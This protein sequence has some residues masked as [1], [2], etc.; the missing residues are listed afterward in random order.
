VLLPERTVREILAMEG[1]ISVSAVRNASP[2][3]LR[4]GPKT[5]IRD[6]VYTIR[7]QDSAGKEPGRS[8]FVMIDSIIFIHPLCVEKSALFIGRQLLIN[9]LCSSVASNGYAQ[10]AATEVAGVEL[11][12]EIGDSHADFT[13]YC[14]AGSGRKAISELP[15][16]L[17]PRAQ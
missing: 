11:S 15:S 8:E 2:P 14:I 3:W 17:F 16:A 12:I 4:L 7:V 13:V 6:R 9:S 5:T 10:P 1:V